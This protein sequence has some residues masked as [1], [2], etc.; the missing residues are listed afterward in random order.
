[1]VK[2]TMFG[3]KIKV[4]VENRSPNTLH[5]ATLVHAVQFTDMHPDD[6]VTFTSPTQP[7]VIAH[8]RTDFGDLVVEAEWFG[9]TKNVDHIVTHR[10]ILISNEAVAWVDTDEYKIAEAA[11]FREMRRKREAGLIPGVEPVAA[12]Q[13][14]NALV[15]QVMSEVREQT[16]LNFES[17]VL[18]DK[19]RLE[20]P[21][22]FSVLKPV[23]RLEV[24]EEVITPEVNQIEGDKI[25]LEFDGIPKGN[26]EQ[27][28]EIN[29]QVS[30]VFADID[31]TWGSNGDGTY[32]LL[33]INQ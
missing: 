16:M 4:A 13:E 23:F 2:P 25:V 12:A 3:N 27:P 9:E 14:S 24:E 8:D 32:T 30:S 17:K 20:L 28:G 18:G 26:S 7:A 5:N 29:L 22:E 15:D 11:E 31:M 33:D 1:V 21:R 10:A 19:V 6:Y